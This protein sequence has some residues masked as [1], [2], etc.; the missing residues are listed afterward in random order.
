MH[1]VSYGDRNLA[2]GDTP[3]TGTGLAELRPTSWA[4]L[5]GLERPAMFYGP[6]VGPFRSKGSVVRVTS[7][8]QNAP[9]YRTVSMGRRERIII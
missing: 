6:Y 7:L 1:R 8:R 3:E 5:W 2:H 9:R 4:G